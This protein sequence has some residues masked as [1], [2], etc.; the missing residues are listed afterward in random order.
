M[1]RYSQGRTVGIYAG[2]LLLLLLIFD[3]DVVGSRDAVY[4]IL[5][6]LSFAGPFIF[7]LGSEVV[8]YAEEEFKESFGREAPK[9][10]AFDFRDG[11]IVGLIW[12]ATLL[13]SLVGP[14]KNFWLMIVPLIVAF[15]LPGYVCKYSMFRAEKKAEQDVPAKSD[16]SGG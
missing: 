7:V 9:K 1:N 10:W 5:L 12:S 6:I 2:L 16:R 14:L 3:F 4:S 13:I 11:L 8:G 15:F